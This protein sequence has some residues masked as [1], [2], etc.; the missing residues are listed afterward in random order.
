MLP[1]WKYAV[2]ILVGIL[3]AN[4]LNFP[5]RSVQEARRRRIDGCHSDPR[6]QNRSMLPPR[7]CPPLPFNVDQGEERDSPEPLAV[8]IFCNVYRFRC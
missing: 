7:T 4:S 6:S 5:S 8:I 2:L 3:N 1:G